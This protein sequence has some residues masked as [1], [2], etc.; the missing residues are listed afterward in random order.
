M[1]ILLSHGDGGKLTHQLIDEV[2]RLAFQDKELDQQG[3]ATLVE[4]R[5]GH[6]LISTDTFVIHPLQF[7]GGDI[8]KL[9]VS[10]T[11]NDLAVSGA[12][13]AYLTA[14]FVLEEGLEI[15]TLKRIVHS[16]AA[17]AKEAGVR[18]IAGDTKVVE[19]GKCDQMYINT[20]GIGF[21]NQPGRLGIGKIRPGDRV[22]INGGIAEHAVA[23]LS[24]RG[25]ISFSS[26]ILSDCCVLNHLVKQ[27]L[28]KFESIRFMRDPTRGGIATTL[29]EISVSAGVDILLEE[30]RIPIKQEVKGAL[31]LLGI[32][33]YYMANEGKILFVVSA[34]EADAFIHFL[35]SIPGFE[36]AAEI[37]VISE[38][39][40]QVL[41]KTLTG[42]TRNLGMLS[43]APLPR[44]C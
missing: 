20:T 18:I 2:F 9:S 40:G 35:R 26:P 30:E 33:P 27:A 31:E 39:N 8:G 4:A 24:E 5:S 7:P 23:V 38:G 44:I 16:M 11:V 29:K 1:K 41:L 21:T 3:D 37:G 22:V 42:G 12:Q 15:G 13:P 14:G 36:M 17:A 10:G 25:G 19:K 28:E 43:G 32:E 6:L 34:G